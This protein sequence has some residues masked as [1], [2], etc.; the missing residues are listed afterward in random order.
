M[1]DKTQTL[2]LRAA[3]VG[4]ATA[5]ATAQVSIVGTPRRLLLGAAREGAP[6]APPVAVAPDEV[7]RVEH[8]NGLVLWM[9]AD[10]L[11]R[12]RGRQGASRDAA[13]EVWEI[14]DSPNLGDADADAQRG[15]ERGALGLGIKA[16]E[17]FGVDLKKKSAALI[18]K[19]FEERRLQRAPG[20]YRVSLAPG[21]AMVAVP[22]GQLVM[23]ADQPVLI[24]LH[25]TLS[26]MQGSFRDLWST[27]AGDVGEA[28]AQARKAIEARY[29]EHVYAFEHRS[30][31]ESPIQNA[32]ALA[33]HLPEGAQVHLVSHSRGGL[34]GELLCLAERDRR[35]DPI[36]AD[37][38]KK[39]F[40]A[41]RTVAE[42]LGLSPL[43]Q[44]AAQ[45][46]DQAY[47]ADRE[48]L[49]QLVKLLDDRQVKV[50]R[51]V[52]VACPARGTTLASG[53]LDRWLSVIN[54]LID[55]ELVSD[56]ADFLLAVVKERTDPRTL[57]G[58]EAMMPGSALT[59]LL[60]HPSLVTTADLSV[61]A[62]DI[63]ASGRWGQISCS[64]PTGF[65]AANTTWWSTPAPWPAACGGPTAARVT[66]ATRA[67]RSRTSTTSATP[68]RCAGWSTV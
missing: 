65:S 24:F 43:D 11:L 46:R 10:D 64:R 54:L 31:T 60:H 58:I 3:G 49:L 22:D 66:C 57:P 38:V 4:H 34:V 41:D 29:G 26:S 6:A 45:E 27:A 1:N 36:R 17:F 28:A 37:L 12:E 7:V 47:D 67:T 61:I 50:R 15:A 35:D 13:G 8:H 23:P 44:A 39:L 63:E 18:G 42:Q 20:L 33:A 16:L 62:G 30:M 59:R 2:T 48:R 53:R 5:P 56:V 32:L 14:D 25:G 9:R 68:S 19:T 52:R 55:N 21:A 40:A 51:F